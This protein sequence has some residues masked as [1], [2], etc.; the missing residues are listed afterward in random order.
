MA[1]SEPVSA[2]PPV[3]AVV[4]P[5]SLVQGMPMHAPIPAPQRPRAARD[6]LDEGWGQAASGAPPSVQM[7]ESATPAE[8]PSAD[9][10]TIPLD[11]SADA[12]TI[13]LEVDRL[14]AL[15]EEPLP[16]ETVASSDDDDE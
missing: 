2:L 9:A 15:R 5:S 1:V 7:S 16:A 6:S 10:E 3:A 11:T 14:A 13:P 8:E 4:P 12:E